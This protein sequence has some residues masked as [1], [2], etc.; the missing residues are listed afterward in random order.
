MQPKFAIDGRPPCVDPVTVRPVVVRL[1]PLAGQQFNV[2]YDEIQLQTVFVPVFDPQHRI[3]IGIQSGQ[4]GLFKL[5]HQ[6]FF[7]LPRQ[8][9]FVERQ[10]AAG[11]P[12]GVTA[13]VYQLPDHLGIAAI[14]R[15]PFPC[16]VLAQQIFHRARPPPDSAAMDFDDH[17]AAPPVLWPR[18]PAQPGIPLC[19]GWPAGWH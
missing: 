1:Q 10:D 3:L 18:R 4:Q 12:L 8:I 7:G 11:V 6:P 2:R 14:Q 9:W 15:G 19:P 5:V 13:A 17:G 16:T